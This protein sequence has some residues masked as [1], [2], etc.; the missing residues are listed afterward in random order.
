[1]SDSPL[2]SPDYEHKTIHWEDYENP[3][4]KGMIATGITLLVSA[5]ALTLIFTL[6]SPLSNFAAFKAAGGYA[7]L[8][9]MAVIGAVSL[10]LLAVNSLVFAKAKREATKENNKREGAEFKKEQAEETERKEAEQL[11]EQQEQER[12]RQE[13]G[14]KLRQLEEAKA[15]QNAKN[16]EI[17]INADNS[18]EVEDVDSDEIKQLKEELTP[19]SLKHKPIDFLC[20]E[21]FNPLF[22]SLEGVLQAMKNSDDHVMNRKIEF[23]KVEKE[24]HQTIAKGKLYV[25]L[26]AHD[27]K[28]FVSELLRGYGPGKTKLTI[29][30][31]QLVAA[32]NS[33]NADLYEKAFKR[34]KAIMSGNNMGGIHTLLRGRTTNADILA[35]LPN[36]L[37]NH[38]CMIDETLIEWGNELLG[39]IF[40]KTQN[41]QGVNQALTQLRRVKSSEL[42]DKMEKFILLVLEQADLNEETLTD[43]NNQVVDHMI[44]GQLMD[45]IRDFLGTLARN[46][47]LLEILFNKNVDKKVVFPQLDDI[48]LESEASN[49]MAPEG[50]ER[51]TLQVNLLK[52]QNQ[53]NQNKKDAKRISFLLV[54][55]GN[56][57]QHILQLCRQMNP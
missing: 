51:R 13:L 20:Q 33:E 34:F 57:S 38:T 26:V 56:N 48:F 2:L 29:A 39:T 36:L 49:W 43:W 31:R 22:D 35:Q 50:E 52:F 46:I 25:N 1:M 45:Q 18:E 16:E 54:P 5:V 3:A 6:A 40:E 9:P 12:I 28:T 32:Y 21:I 7:L 44:G 11:R 19:L 14:E 27:P 24:V 55:L 47:R 10:T 4:K 42:P 15:K 30:L 23:S 53:I 37:K 8:V 41:D 17:E